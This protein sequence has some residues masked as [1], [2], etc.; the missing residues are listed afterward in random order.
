MYTMN[1]YLFFVKK[2]TMKKIDGE[3]AK[4]EAWL[5]LCVCHL[6]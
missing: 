1:E 4:Y 5:E 2:K 3:E 6:C